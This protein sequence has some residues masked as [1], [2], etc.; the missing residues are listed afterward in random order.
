MLD[1]VPPPESV[2]LELRRRQ[3]SYRERDGALSLRAESDPIF[4]RAYWGYWTIEQTGR[5]Q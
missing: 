3:L 4:R 2:L 5:P 1:L